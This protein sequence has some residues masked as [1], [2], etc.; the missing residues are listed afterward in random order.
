MNM[1]SMLVLPAQVFLPRPKNAKEGG[2]EAR[3]EKACLLN[4]PSRG[5]DSVPR[6]KSVAIF[7]LPFDI[8]WK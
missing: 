1:Q 3:D 6:L 8:Y 4:S 2:K 7:L 5:P